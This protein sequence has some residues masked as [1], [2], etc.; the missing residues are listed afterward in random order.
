VIFQ[1]I[2]EKVVGKRLSHLKVRPA[3]ALRVADLTPAARSDVEKTI[4]DLSSLAS[5]NRTVG[6]LRGKVCKIT[7]ADDAH[8]LIGIWRGKGQ[9]QEGCDNSVVQA[10]SPALHGNQLTAK[11][12]TQVHAGITAPDMKG[13]QDR[14]Q[15]LRDEAA[16]CVQRPT[17][18]IGCPRQ[19]KH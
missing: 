2:N 5:A 4:D 3:P 18:L 19:A 11:S 16:Q 13:A 14:I 1:G 9:Q 12:K 8:G 15:R 17:S 10:S 6:I 7:V